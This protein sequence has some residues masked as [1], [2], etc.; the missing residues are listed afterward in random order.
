MQNVLSEKLWAYIIHNNPDLMFSL[1]ESRSVTRYLEEKVNGVLP[2]AEQLLADGNPLYIVEERCLNAMT[3]DLQPSRFQYIRS[4]L[5]DEFSK[6]YERL[7]EN[8]TLTYE[9]V[10]LIETCKNV[11]N[12]FGF[13]KEN[14][15]DRY[16]RYAV[17]G[18]VHSYLT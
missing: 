2:L 18:Q 9:I 12:D 16:L 6:D 14:E 7:K 8:G 4:V 5:E 11:F 3:E 13:S 15:D 10:N 1:Q 17:I